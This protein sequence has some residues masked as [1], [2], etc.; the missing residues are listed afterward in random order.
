MTER[1]KVTMAKLLAVIES[2]FTQ[3]F[4][5]RASEYMPRIRVRTRAGEPNWRAEIRGDVGISVLGPFLAMLDRVKAV[6]DLDDD[7]RDRLISGNT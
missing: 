1:Q 6:Y 2:E 7:A 5:R 3:S 4:G